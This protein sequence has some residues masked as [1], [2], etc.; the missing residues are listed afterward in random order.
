MTIKKAVISITAKVLIFS[1]LLGFCVWCFK[2]ADTVLMNDI[3]LGQMKSSDD[4]YLLLRT[5]EMLRKAATIVFIFLAGSF[6][7]IVGSDIYKIINVKKEN[8]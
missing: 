6:T 4:G 8:Y 3:A 2:T 7:L 1:V 5:Y